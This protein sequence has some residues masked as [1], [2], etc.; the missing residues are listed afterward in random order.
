M[1]LVNEFKFDQALP[2]FELLVEKNYY[3][4]YVEMFNIIQFELKDIEKGG[5]LQNKIKQF[6]PQ[7]KKIAD[8]LPCPIHNNPLACCYFEGL[9]VEKSVQK[10]MEIWRIDAEKGD[11]RSQFKLGLLLTLNYTTPKKLTFGT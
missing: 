8:Q 2:I 7:I 9:G 4:A 3:T 1:Q 5:E 10:A 11:A 6:F